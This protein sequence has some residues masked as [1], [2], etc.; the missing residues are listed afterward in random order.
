LVVFFFMNL[1][2]FVTCDCTIMSPL[3]LINDNA[4]LT[5]RSSSA[6]LTMPFSFY[7]YFFVFIIDTFLVLVK[8]IV[9]VAAHVYIT[10]AA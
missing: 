4:S 9:F 5:L 6:M 10:P 7:F 3:S 8:H 2:F 1:F